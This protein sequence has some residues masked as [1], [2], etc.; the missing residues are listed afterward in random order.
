LLSLTLKNEKMKKQNNGVWIGVEQLQNDPNYL[1]TSK[2]EFTE[3]PVVDDLSK[4]G[5]MD[6]GASRRD[7]LKYLGFGIGA[8]TLAASCDIPVK[9]AIPYVVK[10]DE[11]VPG[12]AT[13]YASSFVQGGDYCSILVKTREGRPIKVEG[14]NLSSVTKGGTSARVQASVLSLYDTSRF[15][16]PYRIKEGKVQRSADRNEKGPSWA[17][18]DKEI[19]EKLT[20]SSNIRIVGYTNMSPTSKKAIEDFK[21]AYPNTEVV[22][23][24]PVSSSAILEA[25]EAN[26]GQ[27]VIPS[28]HFDKAETIVSFDADFLGTWISPVEFAAQYVQNRRIENPKKG[29]KLSRHIQVESHMSLTGSNADNR[30][31]VKPSEQGAAIVALY[32]AIASKAGQG[33]VSGPKLDG[34]KSK[35]I[36]KVADELYGKQGRS[37]V[38]SGSNNKGE[39]MLINGINYMLGNYGKTLEFQHA[40]MQRQGMDKQVSNL[41]QQM[42]AGRVDALFVLDGANPAFDLPASAKFAEAA[43]KV[44]L[45]VTFSQVPNETVDLCDYVTPTH[46]YLESWGDVEPKRGHYSLI[47]PAIAPIFANV[48]RPGTRQTEESMLRWAGY[49]L[50]ADNGEVPDSL[51]TP[52][53]QETT[54][55][56]YDKLNADAGQYYYDYLRKNWQRNFFSQQNEFAT[57][58]AFWDSALHNGVFEVEQPAVEVSLA[59]DMNSA[60]NMVRKPSN[61]ELEVS[62]YETVNLGG[63][64]YAS[65]PW[66]QEMPDPVHRCSWGNY[67]AIPVG[68]DGGNEFTSFKG[69]NPDELKGKADKVDLTVNGTTNTCTVVRQFGQ[70]QGTLALAL[71]YGRSNTGTMGRAV[72]NDVGVDVY[73]WVTYDE[74]GNVQYY[75]TVESVSD[76]VGVE[77]EF[78]CVQYHHSMGLKGVD[79]E[80]GEEINVDEKTVMTLGS[81]FQG[82]LTDRSIIYQGNASELSELVAH[83]EEKRAEA[84]KLNS[85]TLYPYDEYK[86][87]VYGQGHHWAMHIDLNACIGCGACQVACIA[88]NN[89]PVVGKTEVSR[90]HE[91]TWL[92]I[93]R[94]FYGDYENPNTV[95]QPM[96]CQ[97]C[98]NAPCENVCPVAA[99]NHSSEGLN[100]M[101]Y[102]RCIGTRYCANNCPYKVRRFNW[103]DYTTADLFG[104]NEY[105]VN[106]E[107]AAPFG[108][109]NLTRM[110]LNPDVTVRSRGVIEKC[111]FC[112]QRIQEGK[113]TAKREKRQ[114]RDADVKTACQT[115]CPTGAIVFGDLNDKDGEVAKRAEN[116]LNY[117]VLEETNTQAAVRYQAR[118]NNK[119]E[120]LDA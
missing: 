62:F 28:Y 63:G 30:I 58:E 14:N 94:Y 83:V 109:D 13:Y 114:L 40:S 20:A 87:N 88:E 86:E 51:S 59:G 108:A 8:A 16:G 74:N 116:P 26:F 106:G 80:S 25:N 50:A 67:L 9:R 61:A 57:F 79:P 92:R 3:L 75:A 60:A 32:N 82:G 44:K 55:P 17:D 15:D 35:K 19:K 53:Q 29:A 120:E 113:L 42:N 11:I 99:T 97:H 81:G 103:L 38:V 23:Y 43:A 96:M 24:D 21:K 77:D 91:M 117:L 39:Q 34:E 102:N 101:T 85:H 47:Q 104:A 64:T 49:G 27:A 100:Q 90:H 22:T 12:V 56:Y 78:A 70:M 6:V 65:N 18:I 95:Y 93:D 98:D 33:S 36:Q 31:M 54:N 105:S 66:L 52:S 72:G 41:V 1:E 73:P 119:N 48:G 115:A 71:G 2:N 4:E 5:A 111:S 107:D 89:V 118:V 84:Q 68:W 110:V 10:P 45:K 112:V 7:F 37:L 69:L 76:R 46:H